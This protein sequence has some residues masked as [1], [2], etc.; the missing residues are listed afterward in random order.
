MVSRTLTSDEEDYNSDS[1]S[2]P[3]PSTKK[4]PLKAPILSRLR[5]SIFGRARAKVGAPLEK[6]HGRIC[7]TEYNSMSASSKRDSVLAYSLLISRNVPA[8][9][10]THKLLPTSV[11]LDTEASIS[12]MPLWQAR[13]LSVDMNHGK[14]S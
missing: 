4:R 12:L 2:G 5:Q 6:V 10:Q 9:S 8:K 1:G 11:L 13:A 14:I 7:L 3:Q